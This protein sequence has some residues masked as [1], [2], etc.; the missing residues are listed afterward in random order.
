[1]AADRGVFLTGATGL[2]GRYLLR[3]LL[4]TGRRVVV[5]A[6]DGREGSAAERVAQIVAFWAE[7]SGRPL[8]CPVVLAGDLALPGLGLTHADRQWLGRHTRTVI[9]AAANLSF[10]ARLD[11][12]PWRTNVEGTVALLELCR[13]V[14]VSQWHHVS[15]AFVCGQRTGIIR[16]DELNC[17][18]EFHNPYEQSKHEAEQRVRA[19]S[20]L[21]A[22]VYRPSVIVG[23]SRTGYTSSYAGFYRFLELATRLAESPTSPTSPRRL[24]LRLPLTGDERWDLV[25]VDWVSCAIV[26]LV[27]QPQW[28]G[29]TFHLVSRAPVVARLVHAVAAEELNL[30]GVELVG[31]E[32]AGRAGCLEQR[33]LD[34]LQEYW[35][36]LDGEASFDATNTATALPQLPPPLLDR[37]VL[38]RLIRFAAC[39]QWG[40]VQHRDG[41]VSRPCAE[42]IEQTFPRQARQ[43]HLA[44]VARLHLLIALDIRGPGGGQWSCRWTHGELA[45]VRRGLEAKA[46]VV[47]RTDT[48]TFDAILQGRQDA[49]QAFFEQR[50]AITGDL[51][52]ALKLAALFG[53]FLRDHPYS[54]RTEAM[55]ATR[56]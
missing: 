51:E 56:S 37:P 49:Q 23:D 4:L 2:L 15:T 14:G 33:F 36:Y 6:R 21:C 43:S 17:G 40:R 39:A 31:R 25:P 32:G 11:R 45:Y 5:L 47:Y 7:S 22:T 12:E 13:E 30:T 19:A 54:H 8:P 18:Q 50:I 46:A 29:R 20:G 52:T 16:E 27:D 24:P 53:Q 9:H 26:E 34:G 55:D 3:D 35:P 10:R 44:K 1:M 42:Y 48:E 41:I 28:H 38:A